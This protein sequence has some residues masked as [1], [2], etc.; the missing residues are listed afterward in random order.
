[1]I[2]SLKSNYYQITPVA[3]QDNSA[4][5]NSVYDLNQTFKT[6]IDQIEMVVN[7]DDS[8]RVPYTPEQVATTSYSLI[9]STDYFTN[10]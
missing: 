4:R 2:T 9:S 7:F 3:L 6:V 10:S 8:G 1:M 5:M